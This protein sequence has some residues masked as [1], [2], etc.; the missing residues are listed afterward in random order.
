M[1]NSSTTQEYSLS[2]S[3]L[4]CILGACSSVESASLCGR[5]IPVKTPKAQG[6]K[7]VFGKAL[8]HKYGIQIAYRGVCCLNKPS[9]RHMSS[10]YSTGLFFPEAGLWQSESHC[11]HKTMQP[12]NLLWTRIFS[13]TVFLLVQRLKFF[14][15][16]LQHGPSV[17]R[18]VNS[19]QLCIR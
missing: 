19:S 16:A 8:L 18:L 5:S 12:N 6:R 10:N 7:T 13:L 17:A 1:H 3:D 15:K 14:D 9:A 2:G 11:F 4:A